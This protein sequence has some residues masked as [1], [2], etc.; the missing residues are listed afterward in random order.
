MALDVG[1]TAETPTERLVSLREAAR[2]LGITLAAARK[3]LQ[4]GQLAGERR[5]GQWYVRLTDTLHAVDSNWD[6]PETTQRDRGPVLGQDGQQST[7]A[8]LIQELRAEVTALRA[9][10]GRLWDQITARERE[11]SELHVL[12]Q[13]ALEQRPALALPSAEGHEAS[14]TE[15]GSP[16]R[17]RWWARLFRGP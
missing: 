5:Q 13:R 12:L 7:S 6:Q 16:E 3:R 11:V 14:P 2:I 10:E 9:N 1:Q 4:R 15:Q 17:R 8:E